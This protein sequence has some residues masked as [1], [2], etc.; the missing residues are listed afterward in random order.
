[1]AGLPVLLLITFRP[2]FQPPWSGAAHVTTMMLNRLDR[3]ESSALVR[4][5]VTNSVLSDEVV[6]EILERTDGVPLFIEELT[7][8]ML[9]G[10]GDGGV[11][12][13][14]PCRAA[15]RRRFLRASTACRRRNMWR[16]SVR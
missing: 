10:A 7:K 14:L 6:A 3:R 1:M 12:R 9:E 5:I 13:R 8:T 16:K 4:R 11:R 2:E 15:C